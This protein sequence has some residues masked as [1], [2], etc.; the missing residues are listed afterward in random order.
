M[1]VS[2]GVVKVRERLNVFVSQKMA[3]WSLPILSG[4]HPGDARAAEPRLRDEYV[5][6]LAGRSREALRLWPGVSMTFT[7]SPLSLRPATRCTQPRGRVTNPLK[8]AF[9]AGALCQIKFNSKMRCAAFKKAAPRPR[10]S[11]SV[12]D[13]QTRSVLS[14]NKVVTFLMRRACK[15]VIVAC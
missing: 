9:A 12:P 8:C 10:R 2:H 14:L 3:W 1:K 7:I 4:K 6:V 11:D 15:Q 13:S 5:N